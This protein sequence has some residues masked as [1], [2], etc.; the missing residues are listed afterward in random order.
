MR[1]LLVI[2]A[3]V[4]ALVVPGATQASSW[5]PNVC[6]LK[7]FGPRAADWFYCRLF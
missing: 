5:T 3:I 6:H 1:K 7:V 2:A 4:A